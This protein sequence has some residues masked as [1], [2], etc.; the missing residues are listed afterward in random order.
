MT[1]EFLVPYIQWLVYFTFGLVVLYIRTF[2]KEKAKNKVLRLQNSKLVEETELIK[3]KYN[4]EIESLK[5]EYQLEIEKRKYQ[6]ESKKEQY[7]NFFKLLDSFTKEVNKSTQEKLIPIL[8]KFNKDYLNAA[9]TNNNKNETKAVTVMSKQIQ[10]LMF[11]AN[12][13]LVKIKQETNTIRLIASDEIIKKLNLLEL[14]YDKSMEKANNMMSDLPK[15]MLINDQNKMNENQ[16]E[17]QISGMV[18]Q[19]I[20]KD[21]IELM[22][23]ELDEI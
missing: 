17:I 18:I 8:E 6:Y 20:K 15:L 11:S 12:E 13:D 2:V 23:T 1:F 19:N 7:I 10:A 9:N 21:I 3:S 14:A 4:K 22:R 16:R 5:K